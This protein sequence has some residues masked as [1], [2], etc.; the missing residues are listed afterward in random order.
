[1]KKQTF[2]FN[3]AGG[4]GKNI[5]ATAVVASIKKHH[6]ESDIIVTSPWQVVWL[7]NPHV[8]KSL[9]LEEVPNFYEEYLKDKN[10]T[11]LRLEPYSAQDYFFRRK[12]LIEVWCD[13]CKVP[14]DGELPQ[15]YF[16]DKEMEI[17]K[18][19]IFADPE[20]KRPLFFIQPS[21]GPSN[22]QY[23]ISWARDLPISIAEEVVAAMNEKGYRTIHLRR[24]DQIALAGTEWI[25]FNL[26]EAMGAVKFSDKRL[27]VD[28]FGAHAAAAWKLPSVVPWIVNSP[29]VFGYE[30]HTNIFPIAKEVFRHRI[31]SY[32]EAYDIGGKWHEHP[33]ESDK[34]F[35]SKIIVHRLD[36]LPAS[37]KPKKGESP[38]PKPV[39]DTKAA[40]PA[41]A[42]KA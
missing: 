5:M 38:F 4:L 41:S 35:D 33:Y 6:P 36:D 1:M 23:P 22:Q 27:F 28:S 26:R 13:L 34:I 17:I 25:S 11:M 15:L 2:I 14:Y 19:K 20:D 18:E 12:N 24:A 9:S 40:G 30:M 8:S 31:D 16:T 10:C 21:G 7:N 3:I 37:Y 29:T 39:A 32:L 42:K